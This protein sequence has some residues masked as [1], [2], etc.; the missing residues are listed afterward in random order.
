MILYKL[1]ISPNGDSS[2]RAFLKYLF[3]LK[4]GSAKTS[5]IFPNVTAIARIAPFLPCPPKVAH[6]I[7]PLSYRPLPSPRHPTHFITINNRTTW[8]KTIFLRQRLRRDVYLIPTVAHEPFSRN[9]LLLFLYL[10][11]HPY[12]FSRRYRYFVVSW[13]THLAVIHGNN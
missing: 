10:S 5:S 4:E 12:F 7:S 1:S 13:T 11:R 9:E 6:I 2:N 8:G 3:C